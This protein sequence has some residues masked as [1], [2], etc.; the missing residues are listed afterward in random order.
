MVFTRPKWPTSSRRFTIGTAMR[1]ARAPGQTSP[2]ACATVSASACT[3]ETVGDDAMSQPNAL[4]VSPAALIWLAV[5]ELPSQALSIFQARNERHRTQR[6]A[7]TVFGVRCVSAALLYLSQ[8]VLARWMGSYEYG[9]YVF[10]WTWVMILGGLADLGLWRRHHPLRP[11]IPRER[12]AGARCAAS[13]GRARRGARPRHLD[14][15]RRRCRALP[16]RAA[17]QPLHAAG[18]PRPGVRADLCAHLG[19]GRHRQGASR[20]WGCRWCRPTWCARRCCSSPWWP[21]TRSACRWRP[22]PPPRPR[23][24]PPGATGIV[25]TLLMNRRLERHRRNAATCNTT[26]R[27]GC[28]RRGRCS[29]SPPASSPCRAP[30]CSSSRTT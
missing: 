24:S 8:I 6:D 12:R 29:S 21:R 25:Q 23:S 4:G 13:C 27:C 19:A 18:L 7:V 26:S 3:N 10:V 17:R 20:G 14:R 11:P 28:G 30:T 1:I 15:R 5:R 9:I 16:L 2:S 22:R